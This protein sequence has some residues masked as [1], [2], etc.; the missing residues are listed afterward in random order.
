MTT[1]RLNKNESNIINNIKPNALI[2]LFSYYNL[3]AIT[4]NKFE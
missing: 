1:V 2:K 4:H 3:I